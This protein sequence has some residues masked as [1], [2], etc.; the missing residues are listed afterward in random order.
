M[1][2]LPM[3]WCTSP[4][5]PSAARVM[6]TLEPT[7]ICRPGVRR[8]RA[9]DGQHHRHH[10]CEHPAGGDDGG[11]GPRA[12]TDIERARERAHIAEPDQ[13][14]ARRR[15]GGQQGKRQIAPGRSD[16]RRQPSR[17]HPVRA[18]RRSGAG[19]RGTTEAMIAPSD[20]PDLPGAR[21]RAI[22]S[23]QHR[24]KAVAVAVMGTASTAYGDRWS[25][26][27][28]LIGVDGAERSNAD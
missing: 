26:L 12:P 9:P 11:R 27:D 14:P 3:Q 21:V 15:H 2:A 1:A 17:R 13:A 10:G 4:S 8:P 7:P 28:V 20:Q 16:P 24:E 23:R 5:S 6:P 22:A 19:N 18:R 25:R